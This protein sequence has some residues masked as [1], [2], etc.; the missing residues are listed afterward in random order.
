MIL[1]KN[2]KKVIAVVLCLI[3]VFS[4]MSISASA[5]RVSASLGYNEAEDSGD[6]AQ[7][8][9]G[10][11]RRSSSTTVSEVKWMQSALNYCLAKE[12]LAGK[13]ARLKVDG[14]F[15]PKAKEATIAFQKAAGLNPDGSFGP[16]TIKKIKAVLNDG[17]DN[18][19]KPKVVVRVT[20]P[21]AK[22]TTTTTT[23]KP[24]SSSNF[25]QQN[26]L[27]VSAANSSKYISGDWYKYKYSGT[28][29][30]CAYCGNL[31]YG[32]HEYIQGGGCGV[33]SLVSAIYNLGGT[34][35]KADIDS[36][37]KKVLN[38]G[39]ETKT[40]SGVRY[41]QNGVKNRN[42]FNQADEKF[43]S[44]YGFTIS[45]EISGTSTDTKFVNHIKNG[46]TA[47]VHVYS[48][49]MA[50]VDYKV[51]NGQVYFYV[52][53]PAPGSGSNY[54][55]SKRRGITTAEGCWISQADLKNDGGSKGS[56]GSKENIEIDAYWLV[57]AK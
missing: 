13:F 19:L 37:I 30:K 21:T 9:N 54:N 24:S 28:N 39:Y 49:F 10:K 8:T 2:L 47:V 50:V 32:D 48:H 43:G 35:P 15:G 20:Q 14:S 41:W 33:V 57:S 26:I 12:G 51:E 5:A 22:K 44:T 3:T 53:D 6:W 45:N 36:A 42:L 7:Y 23:Q 4:V 46:G 40:K 55:S 56:K 18:T 25:K 34:I 31:G 11:V 38:W 1:V 52:F 16:A 27:Q 29:C 17:R